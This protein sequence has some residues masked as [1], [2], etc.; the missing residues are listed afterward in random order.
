MTWW[1][2]PKWSVMK[3]LKFEL[4]FVIKLVFSTVFIFSRMFGKRKWKNSGK[5]LSQVFQTAYQKRYF[6][7]YSS[8][9]KW[10][11]TLWKLVFTKFEHKN[12]LFQV[13]DSFHEYGGAFLDEL[14]L[15]HHWTFTHWKKSNND[16]KTSRRKSMA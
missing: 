14:F 7:K 3:R 6:G 11:T 12:Y 9:E 2:F 13:L 4:N 16:I 5:V 10:F 8:H 15:L 1:I